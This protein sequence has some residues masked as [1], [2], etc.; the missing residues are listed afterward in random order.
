MKVRK[1][2]YDVVRFPLERSLI[3]DSMRISNRKRVIHGL[4]EVDVTEVRTYMREHKARTGERLSFTAFILA[5]LGKAVDEHKIVHAYRDRRQRLVLFEEVDVTTMIE[6]KLGD[7]KFPYAH[8]VRAAN[9]RNYRELH[10]E[11]RAVQSGQGIRE[12]QEQ[13]KFMRW[14]LLLPPFLRDIAYRFWLGNP[15]L[16]KARIGTVGLTAVGMFGEGAGWGLSNPIYTLGVMVGGISAKPWAV[17][18]RIE[19]RE[20]LNLTVGFDHDIVDGAPAARFTKR[21]KELIEVGYG[22]ME[23]NTQ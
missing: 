3:V 19:I 12:S 11:I 1:K 18:G 22:P 17:D 10:D 6:I 16:V 5:C 23:S 7:Q 21:L 13:W 4:L 20:I 15:H 9:R 8:I 14:F 2:E